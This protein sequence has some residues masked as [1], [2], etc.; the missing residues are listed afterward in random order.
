MGLQNPTPPR[1]SPSSASSPEAGPTCSPRWPGISL[2]FYAGPPDE[3]C[4]QAVAELCIAAG[5]DESLIPGWIEE[6]WRRAEAAS[7]PPFSLPARRT[8]PDR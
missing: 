8:L 7:L 2:G 1:R 6:G 5:A 3:P 4:A